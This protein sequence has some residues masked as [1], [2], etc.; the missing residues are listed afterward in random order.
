VEA[1]LVRG[2]VASLDDRPPDAGTRPR[3]RA[4]LEILGRP[5]V[6]Y[7]VGVVRGP[8]ATLV[9]RYARAV[10]EAAGAPTGTLADELDD[11]LLELA[12]TRAIGAAYQ[13][14]TTGPALGELSQLE[15]STLIALTAA[16]DASRRV[17]LVVDE[18]ADPLAPA[19]VLPSDLSALV[20]L[21]A[22]A[23]ASAIG[24]AP[25]ARPLVALAGGGSE[26]LERV[27]RLAADRE[28]PLVLA[29]R[30]FDLTSAPDAF[31]LRV[32]DERYDALPL[33]PGEDPWLAATGIVT[34]LGL[35]ALGIRM[36]AEWVEAGARR[37]A[38]R[39]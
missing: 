3:V 18:D 7:L 24:D 39:E 17:L 11:P 23:L 33:G 27:A 31:D 8:G 28:L 6:R 2:F 37:A 34:A 30:D 15:L 26:A 14:A 16:A 38:R 32:G 36:R 5:D 29:G 22:D 19:L 9:A 4:C 13:L 20:R 21:Q 1:A 25:D 10:L 12:G 35:G